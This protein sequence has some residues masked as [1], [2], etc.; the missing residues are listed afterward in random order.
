[1]NVITCAEVR[2]RAP[3]LA[4][5]VLAGTER[6]DV[7]EHLG[8]CARCRAEVGELSEVADLLPKLAP[9]A[10]PPAGFDVRVLSTMRGDR[11]R[12]L[13]RRGATALTAAAAAAILSIVIVRVIDADRAPERAESTVA[14][15]TVAMV[16]PAGLPVGQVAVSGSGTAQVAVTVDYSVPD[17]AYSLEVQADPA[18]PRPIGTIVVRGGHG[19]WKGSGPVPRTRSTV[20]MTDAEGTIVCQAVVPPV[21]I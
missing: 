16:G 3:E 12:R 13:L 18:A 7:L 1:M 11:R 5:D 2:D 4:L 14:L 9:E 17:G 8:G 21:R 15:R 20:A 6:A 19:A 10:E